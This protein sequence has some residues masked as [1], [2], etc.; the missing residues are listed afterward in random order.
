MKTKISKRQNAINQIRYDFAKNGKDTG[1]STRYYV[2]TRIS[3]DTFKEAA[4]SGLTIFKN[5]GK[6]NHEL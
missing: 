1:I 4:R 5:G 6:L 2:E 3:Y